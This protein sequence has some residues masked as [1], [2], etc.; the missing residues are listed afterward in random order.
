MGG[1]I[2][3]NGESEKMH[4]KSCSGNVRGKRVRRPR[5]K[6]D[7]NIRMNFGGTV[8]KNIYWIH[9]ALVIDQ[10]W[11]LVNTAMNLRFHK[12][13]EILLLASEDGPCT[14]FPFSEPVSSL[15]SKPVPAVSHTC[16]VKADGVFTLDANI[17]LNI[18]ILHL[19]IYWFQ[20][21]QLH[22]TIIFPIV[23]MNI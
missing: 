18:L 16:Q 22:V 19:F 2:V 7:D 21:H 1:A 10:K 12:M 11:V 13:R 9:L 14:S 8:T 6:W 20:R 23:V 4:K 17:R 15:T 3:A 5:N